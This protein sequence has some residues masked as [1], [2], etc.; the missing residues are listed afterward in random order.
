MILTQS[1]SSTTQIVSASDFMRKINSKIPDIL[2]RTLTNQWMIGTYGDETGNFPFI[3]LKTDFFQNAFA[4]MLNWESAMPDDFAILFNY[5]DK[6]NE[7]FTIHG[8]FQDRTIL[9]RDIREFIN[10]FG[11]LILLYSFID[12]DTLVITTSETTL[13]GII[14]KV[15]KQALIRYN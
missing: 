5:N 13:K 1:I 10:N 7:L 12:K 14:E 4:G 3:I 15:E 11:E 2:S 6:I 9:N 8:K